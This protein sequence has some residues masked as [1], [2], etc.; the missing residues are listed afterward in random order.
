MG[1]SVGPIVAAALAL[2]AC[3]TPPEWSERVT[4]AVDR[5]GRELVAFSVSGPSTPLIRGIDDLM[6]CVVGMDGAARCHHRDGVVSASV[7]PAAASATCPGADAVLRSPCRAGE[8]CRFSGVAVPSSTFA[9]MIVELRVPR[10]GVPRHV[11]SDAAVV[12]QAPALVDAEA[13]QLQQRLRAVARC[14]APGAGDG[15]RLAVVDRRACENDF[16]KLDRSRVKLS[17]EREETR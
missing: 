1:R 9:M 3:A 14:L 10:F 12:S 2:G 6:L 8:G 5:G 15:P 16:C 13:P 17:R 4:V 11:V 7:A